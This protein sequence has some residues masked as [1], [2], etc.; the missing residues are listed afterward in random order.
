MRAGFR[1]GRGDWRA[2]YGVGIFVLHVTC[3]GSAV[4]AGGGSELLA[5]APEVRTTVEGQVGVVGPWARARPLKVVKNRE[6]CGTTV[7]NETLLVSRD[8]GLQN[9]VVVLKPVKSPVAV[10]PKRIVLDNKNC[11]FVPHVQAA[12]VGSEV[13]LKNSDPI[14]HAVHARIGR[15]TLFNIGL[16]RWREVARSLDRTGVLRIDCDVLHTW[17]S[18]AIVVTPSPYFA[19]T[20]EQANFV[21]ENVPWGSYEAEIWH[22][23]LGIR[24][25]RVW[26]PEK[27]RLRLDA[28]YALR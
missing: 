7:P 6:F 13:V 16:P 27:S 15:Q 10:Q 18:A 3:F 17:M 1:N 24:S 2:R 12:V 11:A 8:G 23:T 9:A 21:I 28:V 25:K 4:V 26:V 14:L 5:P 19:V 22:E 20:D